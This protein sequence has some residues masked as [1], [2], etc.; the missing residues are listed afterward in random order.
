M[1]VETRLQQWVVS[2]PYRIWSI[3]SKTCVI[4][5][6]TSLIAFICFYFRF[7]V[8]SIKEEF[9][10]NQTNCTISDT[11]TNNLVCDNERQQTCEL[12]IGDCFIVDHIQNLTVYS[13]W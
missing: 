11:K 10:I 6:L 13:T 7:Y 8:P 2:C 9:Y 5:F 4:L 12:I 1:A 3:I